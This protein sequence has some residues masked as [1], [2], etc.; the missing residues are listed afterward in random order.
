LGKRAKKSEM[1]ACRKKEIKR[2][3]FSTL[4]LPCLPQALNLTWCRAGRQS[5][6]LLSG[7]GKGW[8]FVIFL[9]L[10]A[11]EVNI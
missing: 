9:V 1:V 11:E 4:C 3:V 7:F 5:A 10:T 8:Q 2:F 6:L